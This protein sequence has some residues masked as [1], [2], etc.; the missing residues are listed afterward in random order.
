MSSAVAAARHQVR[1]LAVAFREAPEI[2]AGIALAAL[3]CLL[4]NP[5]VS[6]EELS[7]AGGLLA[8]ATALPLMLRRRYPVGVLTVVVAGVLGC[9]VVF[10]PGQGAVGVTMVA[11]YTVGA[12]GRRTRSLLIGAAMAPLVAAAVAIASRHGFQLDDMVTYLALVLVALAAGDARRGRL[13][14]ARA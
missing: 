6:G 9:L 4:L 8:A 1:Q 14:L 13:A 12:E 10:K 11:I 7:L 3:V 5:V 2:D